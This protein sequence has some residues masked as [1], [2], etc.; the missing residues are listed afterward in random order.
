[1]CECTKNKLDVFITL[2]IGKTSNETLRCS[3]VG[4]YVL[5]SHKD[6]INLKYAKDRADSQ[7]VCGPLS[8]D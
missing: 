1:M 8:E 6:Y 5:S 7:F 2:L 3:A 4:V